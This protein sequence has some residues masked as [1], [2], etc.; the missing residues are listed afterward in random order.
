[1]ADSPLRVL[2][3]AVRRNGMTQNTEQH[4]AYLISALERA[5]YK[6]VPIG[7]KTDG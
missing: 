7:E 4:A 6:I 1:M 2:A 5:G 3:D